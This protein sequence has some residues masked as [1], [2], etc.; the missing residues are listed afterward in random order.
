[1]MRRPPSIDRVVRTSSLGAVIP[2]A[3]IAVVAL[4]ALLM[5]WATTRGP[6]L[7]PDSVYYASAARSW[8]VGSGLVQYDGQPLT[9]FPPGLS[10]LLGA[11]EALGIDL[12]TSTVL[13]NMASAVG[14]L[15]LTYLIA[16]E[17]M[18]S[19]AWGLAAALLVGT[20]GTLFGVHVM[21][22]SE[23][24]FMLSAMLAL[25]LLQQG[26]REQRLARRRVVALVLAVGAACTFRYVGFILVPIVLLGAILARRHAPGPTRRGGAVLEA[27]V[28]A[29]ISA[30]PALGVMARNVALGAAPMGERA[31]PDTR[32]AEVID[33]TVQTLGSFIDPRGGVSPGATTLG[34]L[35]AAGM[36]VSVVAT[37]L[38][39]GPQHWLL[40]GYLV[41]YVAAIWWAALTTQLDAIDQRLL[42]PALPLIVI[43]GLAV[44]QYGLQRPEVQRL[45]GSTQRLLRL[46]LGALVL[47]VGLL[48]TADALPRASDLSR[49]GIG[50]NHVSSLASPLANAVRALPPGGVAASDPWLT[51]WVSGRT[52]VLQVPRTGDHYWSPERT[53]LE[54]QRLLGAVRDGRVGYI[55]LW[56]YTVTALTPS[57]LAESGLRLTE[58]GRYGDGRLYTTSFAPR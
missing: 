19:P 3:V 26:I 44:A 41:S 16:R 27:L 47:A 35:V 24:L 50:Y 38:R 4:P 20:S 58:V 15:W 51:Y 23:P 30:V 14:V 33:R 42:A 8:A 13:L 17:L 10:L 12:L 37:V 5:L 18:E 39:W 6:G 36:V 25:R 56:D 46:A 53:A 21:L 54:T 40:C 32:I 29:G 1:M 9:W 57:Q 55:A 49:T 11:G 43:L 34:V 2:T 22:W 52:P 45:S 28:I 7:S 31:R 48:N